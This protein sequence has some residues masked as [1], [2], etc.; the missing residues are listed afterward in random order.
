MKEEDDDAKNRS[1][2]DDDADRVSLNHAKIGK[3]CEREKI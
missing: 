2:T 1:I 3:L